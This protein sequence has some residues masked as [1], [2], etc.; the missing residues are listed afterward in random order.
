MAATQSVKTPS[1]QRKEGK[2]E[3][4]EEVD[5]KAERNEER[6]K[7]RSLPSFFGHLLLLLPRF[8][9]PRSSIPSFFFGEPAA[10][11]AFSYSLSFSPP[12]FP[13]SLPSP[14]PPG[15]SEESCHLH[16]THI[17]R[18]ERRRKVGASRGE[19][20]RKFLGG[21]WKERRAFY[22]SLSFSHTATC[23]ILPSPPLR[24]LS[25]FAR[26]R[27]FKGEI[28]RIVRSGH[29]LLVWRGREGVGQEETIRGRTLKEE[30]KERKH[31]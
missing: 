8:F 4:E 6:K 11:P 7:K 13:S 10:L 3:E 30:T 12:L 28:T 20:D 5:E 29:L 25:S 26:R 23:H 1:R 27:G 9:L 31:A 17:R 14:L 2:E 16:Q 19:E 21:M 15:P 24:F 18:Q 22:I